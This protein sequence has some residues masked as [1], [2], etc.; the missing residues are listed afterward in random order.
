[1]NNK[2]KGAKGELL[3]AKYLSKK[4]Y[5]IIDKNCTFAGAELD[6]V[7]ILPQKALKKRISSEI[8]NAKDEIEKLALEREKEDAEDLLVFVEVKYSETL[9]FG[10]PYMRVDLHKQ[11]QL[12]KAAELFMK[13][14]K[15]DMPVRF[16][17][18][19]I[20]ADKLEHI[21]GAFDLT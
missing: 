10:E 5:K 2:A 8:K 9:E 16:D 12:Y 11:H 18:I 13:K 6:I 15:L 3:A 1:M 20:V 4:G 7:C 21:E 19:S 14:N 17:V